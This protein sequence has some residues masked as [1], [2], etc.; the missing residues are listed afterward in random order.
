MDLP[1]KLAKVLPQREIIN[2]VPN[3]ICLQEI[4]YPSPVRLKGLRSWSANLFLRLQAKIDGESF[5]YL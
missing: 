1:N 2:N 4:T 5:V 3:F